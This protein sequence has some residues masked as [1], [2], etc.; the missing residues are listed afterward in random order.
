MFDFALQVPGWTET[1]AATPTRGEAFPWLSDVLRLC[2]DASLEIELEVEYDRTNMDPVE[3]DVMENQIADEAQE[4]YCH[5]IDCLLASLNKVVAT[6]KHPDRAIDER[7]ARR[8]LEAYE[9]EAKDGPGGEPTQRQQEL[10]ARVYC[11]LV[12]SPETDG[13]FDHSQ[14]ARLLQT[15]I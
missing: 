9:W 8:L 10:A 12:M 6:G 5:V 15:A 13:W 4:A 11:S 3:F 2:G 7:S 1:M 14:T